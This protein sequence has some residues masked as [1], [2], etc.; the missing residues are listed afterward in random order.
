MRSVAKPNR[1]KGW[2]A[3][4]LFAVAAASPDTT[5]PLKEELA[6]YCRQKVNRINDTGNSGPG[7]RRRLPQPFGHYR[8]VHIFSLCEFLVSACES[9]GSLIAAQPDRCREECRGNQQSQP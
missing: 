7:T 8:R 4:M 9:D 5:S 2:C 3:R 6:E 1:N